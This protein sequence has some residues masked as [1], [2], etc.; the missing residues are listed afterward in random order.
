MTTV[1]LLHPG[2]MGAVVGGCLV[3]AGH[4]VLWVGEGRSDE[5]RARGAAARLIER[6]TI[7]AAVAESE[8]VLSICPPEF[9]QQVAHAVAAAG[10]GGVYVDANAIAPERMRRIAEVVGDRDQVVDGGI[11]GPP[12]HRSGTTRLYLCG[13]G[14]PAIAALF[15]GTA[16]EAAVLDEEVGAASALKLAYASYQK[17]SR[18]LGALAHALAREHGVGPELER[19][20]ELLR[21][22][23]LAETDA[24]ASA[25]AKAWRWAPEMREAA[26]ALRAAGLPGGVAEGAALA[27]ARW[28]P[29]KDR[30]DLR[31]DELLRMLARDLSSEPSEPSARRSP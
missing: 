8:V 5:T 25:A 30:T 24:F 2:A 27:L 1:T 31:V 19:E 4:R 7:T 21:S 14:A 28:E 23:P 17:I 9:A 20:A 16:L 26:A 15:D 12:P 11:I 10:F 18:V 3:T 22:R 13:A 6:P 29:A